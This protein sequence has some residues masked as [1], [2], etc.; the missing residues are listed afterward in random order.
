M[1]SSRL[2]IKLAGVKTLGTREFVGHGATFGNVDLGGDIIAPGAFSKSLAQHQSAGTWPV[3]AWAH[4]TSKIPGRWLDIREDAR[5]LA[6]H[7]ILA[8]TP[9]GNEVH[10]LLKMEAVC[11]L[12]IGYQTLDHSFDRDGHRLLK[13]VA[14]HEI[15]VVPLPMNPRATVAGVKRGDLA[16]TIGD[17]RTYENFVRSAYGLSRGG[18]K[19]LASKTWGAFA[20]AIGADPDEAELSF[21]ND[22]VDLATAV[23]VLRSA[24][25]RIRSL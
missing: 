17:I 2:E 6:V 19:R 13:Q 22:D 25:S 12:S 18:A 9:L 4:D 10:T 15:S 3:M 23:A 21:I 20:E 14:L 1:A 16:N 5:G 8:D 24:A 11:G 7:G